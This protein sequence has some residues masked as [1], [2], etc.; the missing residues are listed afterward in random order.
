VADW[1][2]RGFYTDLLNSGIRLFL[3]QGA[4]VHSKTAVIDGTWS[5]IGTA[6]LDR[7][8]LWG[9]YEAN[10]EITDRDVA[11]HMEHVFSVDEGNTVEL[12]AEAWLRRPWWKKFAESLL[13][14]WRPL[15]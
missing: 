9:N 4:M 3:Y 7:L 10:L 6:N 2:S 5:T 11:S 14:P 8:S 15:F 1:L 13:S 12:T